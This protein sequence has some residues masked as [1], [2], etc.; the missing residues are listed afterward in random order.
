MNKMSGDDLDLP[1]PK[2][3]ND[4]ALRTME[5]RGAQTRFPAEEDIGGSRPGVPSRVKAAIERREAREADEDGS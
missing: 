2:V 4:R 5:E 3:E 1:S